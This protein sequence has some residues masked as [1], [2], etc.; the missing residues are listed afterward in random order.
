MELQQKRQKV[1]LVLASGGA[2][3]LAHIGVIR[4]L[5]K[6]GFEISSVSGSSVGSLIGGIY[7]SGQLDAFTEWVLNLDEVDVFDLIDFTFTARGFI[8]AERIFN[9]FQKFLSKKNIEDLSIPFAAVA[10]DLNTR[11]EFIF[12]EGSLVQAIRA[13]VAI[14]SIITP[15]VN[16]DQILVDGGVVSPIPAD[17][18]ARHHGDLLFV[19]DINANTPYIKPDVPARPPKEHEYSFKRSIFNAVRNNTDFFSSDGDQKS[20]LGYLDVLNKTFDIMQD[21]IC[22]LTK[23]N[24]HPD[25]TVEISRDA[26]TT[27]EFYRAAELIEAGKQAF[28]VAL[29]QYKKTITSGTSN[30]E[31]K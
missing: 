1:A 15:V 16:N 26:A 2:R 22:V 31:K 23:Q 5:E 25:I 28:Y 7:V 13:S 21:S 24:Y 30:P 17:A 11:K 6:N 27:F 12:R 10:V 18:V 4:E 8:K 20:G 29:E 9:V 14:P 3:G 19:S